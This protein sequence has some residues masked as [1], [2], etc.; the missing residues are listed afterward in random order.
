[1]AKHRAHKTYGKEASLAG[2]FV[3]ILSGLVTYTWLEW[4][5]VKSSLMILLEVLT[6]TA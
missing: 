6:R 5:D 2:A 1:M 3:F 4:N